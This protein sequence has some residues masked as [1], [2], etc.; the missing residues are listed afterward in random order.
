[1]SRSNLGAVR[2]RHRR[3][4]RDPMRAF[5]ALPPELRRWMAN[6]TLPWSPASCE[7]IW[8]KSR[9]AGESVEATCLRLGRAETA[10]LQRAH[11]RRKR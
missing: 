7:K 2:L 10:T 5:D 4:V 11:R 1:M 3:G 6:A 8:R 9:A